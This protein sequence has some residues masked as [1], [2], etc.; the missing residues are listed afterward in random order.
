MRQIW[1]CRFCGVTSRNLHTCRKGTKFATKT[2]SATRKLP[3]RRLI[4]HVPCLSCRLMKGEPLLSKSGIWPCA[5]KMSMVNFP[6]FFSET[7]NKSKAFG[8]A[9]T[10]RR[11]SFVTII[12]SSEHASNSRNSFSLA[13]SSCRSLRGFSI[14]LLT[15][16]MSVLH[17]CR[18]CAVVRPNPVES[19]N[20]NLLILW[21]IATIASR[22]LAASFRN[23]FSTALRSS[24]V[25][26][27]PSLVS[28]LRARRRCAVPCSNTVESCDL[29]LEVSMGAFPAKLDLSSVRCAQPRNGVAYATSATTEAMI[30]GLLAD[31][32]SLLRNSGKLCLESQTQVGTAYASSE[33]LHRAALPRSPKQRCRQ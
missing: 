14:T 4:L 22:H 11:L 24:P 33:A 29:N 2:Y 17:A 13:C 9:A 18:R 31:L 12:A 6:R 7:P 8:F 1:T 26:L 23:S 27:F 21:L 30:T 20:L 3:S 16:P 10:K 25:A 15:G 19:C 5:R 32:R 28:V